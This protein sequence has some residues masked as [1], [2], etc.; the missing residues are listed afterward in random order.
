MTIHYTLV[1]AS[2]TDATGLIRHLLMPDP[3]KRATIEAI[4]RH[5][6]I[7]LGYDCTPIEQYPPIK[8]IDVTRLGESISLAHSRRNSSSESD[9]EIDDTPPIQTALPVK[10]ILKKTKSVST[11]DEDDAI[12]V[13]KNVTSPDGSTDVFEDSPVGVQKSS[14]PFDGVAVP[15][16]SRKP[17]RGILKNKQPS[18]SDSGCGLDD[19]ELLLATPPGGY[20]CQS[21]DSGNSYDLSDI[22]AVLGEC[23]D[24]KDTTDGHAD[25]AGCVYPTDRTTNGFEGQTSACESRSYDRLN[26]DGDLPHSALGVPSLVHGGIVSSTPLQP[27]KGILKRRR[28]LSTERDPTWRYSLG[29]QGSNSSGDI[30]DFSYDS[31]DA[32]TYLSDY[33]A[34]VS[35]TKPQ[36]FDNGCLETVTDDDDYGPPP[37]LPRT[38]PPQHRHSGIYLDD[39]DDDIA[40]HIPVTPNGTDLGDIMSRLHISPPKKRQPCI[41]DSVDF[42]DLAEARQVCQ[43]ALT[44]GSNWG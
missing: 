16:L 26:D 11:D 20:E 33:L 27:V 44:I 1:L 8:L 38:A 25:A 40:D 14:S 7:N 28:K 35:E 31:A 12:V 9:G 18:Y 3:K 41:V 13:S 5:W 6:W 29:S 21:K 24:V 36:I 43:Q 17:R 39:D 23:S 19:T 4:C 32:D 2:R 15:D 10:G 42:F 34:T 30:L 37:P 22:E